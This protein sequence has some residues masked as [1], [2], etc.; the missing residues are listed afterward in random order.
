MQVLPAP[1]LRRYIRHYLFL[2]CNN[3]S[4]NQLRLFADGNP[5]IVFSM[6]SPLYQDA[7]KREPLPS[8]FAYGQ[9]SSS[10]V[11]HSEGLTSLIVVVFQPYGM[12]VLFNISAR[13]L[14]DQA[15]PLTDL[16]SDQVGECG[17]PE[18]VTAALD[19]FFL[20]Q[21]PKAPSALVEYVVKYIEASN[22]TFTLSELRQHTGATE[23][24]IERQFNIM[25]GFGPK[26]LGDLVKLNAFLKRMRNAPAGEK[27]TSIAYDSG[28]Y[29]Q[30]HSIKKFRKITGMTPLQYKRKHEPLALNFVRSI[31]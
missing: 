21:S 11:I 9:L 20:N 14:M 24:Q 16:V 27:L 17:S 1:G 22:G 7:H 25:V 6:G 23:R 4:I 31:T 26:H 19:R 12:S 8:A 5:G 30:A 28:Y 3:E 29:D 15:I 18:A 2:D 13:E 10:R